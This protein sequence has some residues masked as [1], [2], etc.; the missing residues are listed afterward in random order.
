MGKVKALLIGVSKYN[1]SV[2]DDLPFC[3]NDLQLINNSLKN[4]LR[5]EE[6]DII[7]LGHDGFVYEKE[8]VSEFNKLKDSI[9]QDDVLFAYFSGHAQMSNNSHYLCFSDSILETIKYIEYIS[10]INCKNKIIII[11]ACYCKIDNLYENTFQ[12]LDSIHKNIN[13]GTVIVTSSA[14]EQKSYFVQSAE[15]STFTYFLSS[16]LTNNSFVKNEKKSLFKI[17]YT[18]SMYMDFYNN[19]TEGILQS[20]QIFS[21]ILGDVLFSI[22][23]GQVYNNKVYRKN[24]RS[25]VIHSI[26]PR[27]NF[28]AKRYCVK[29]VLKNPTSYNEIIQFSN[30]I[31]K[32]LKKL[33]VFENDIQKNKG[34]NKKS[35][36]LFM[37]FYLTTD[38]AINC[39]HICQ[40]TWFN[41]TKKSFEYVKCHNIHKH[42]NNICFQINENYELF[43]KLQN[44]NVPTSEG[45][46]KYI[47]LALPEVINIGEIIIS[48]FTELINKKI[49]IEQYVEVLLSLK[50]KVNNYYLE[51][52]DI[53]VPEDMNEIDK[54]YTDLI[55]ILFDIV[56]LSDLTNNDI[57]ILSEIYIIKYKSTLS[58][59]DLTNKK[60]KKILQ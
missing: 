21:D 60:L 12:S 56:H 2:A 40:T 28:E 39:Y 11:D 37:Y 43:K 49:Y 44:T 34:R 33:N 38:D 46:K 59:I 13:K 27:H 18:T 15:V 50:N 31:V 7:L 29:I 22:K 16:A 14:S 32:K 25:Y 47:D 6:K 57:V 4:G 24:Y 52:S 20:P 17:L 1:E 55:S 9:K 58:Q 23:S 35:D 8:L 36:I 54:I 51:I 45:Y 5:I 42:E 48:H 30:Q 10:S 26:E 53:K 3:K 19:N 41:D